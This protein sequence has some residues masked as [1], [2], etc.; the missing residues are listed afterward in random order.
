MT[1]G[2]GVQ[3][4]TK[5]PKYLG[6][7]P[8]TFEIIMTVV[9]LAVF[10]SAT[11]HSAAVVPSEI[12]ALRRYLQLQKNLRWVHLLS[13]KSP[14]GITGIGGVRAEDRPRKHSMCG[15]DQGLTTIHPRILIALVVA[16]AICLDGQVINTDQNAMGNAFLRAQ[17]RLNS[18]YVH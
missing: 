4:P 6:M 16:I 1:A 18:C 10:Y 15:A 2:P 7:N 14:G 8:S 3:D 11:C 13:R 5:T 17:H 12:H 9:L